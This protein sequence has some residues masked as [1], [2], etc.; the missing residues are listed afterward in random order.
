MDSE[1]DF[2]FLNER[3]AEKFNPLQEWEYIVIQ[4]RS[5]N[6]RLTPLHRGFDYQ[7]A[8]SFCEMENMGSDYHH[9]TVRVVHQGI[10]YHVGDNGLA[11][12]VSKEQ[13]WEIK[14]SYYDARFTEDQDC[15]IEVC[16][17]TYPVFWSW[18]Q[19]PGAGGQM[20]RD[21]RPVTCLAEDYEREVNHCPNCNQPLLSLLEED[22]DPPGEDEDDWW[23]WE[24]VPET[25][26]G[27]KYYNLNS[28]ISCAIHPSGVEENCKDYSQE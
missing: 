13:N 2:V 23:D 5:S 18:R 21:W 17:C 14:Q 10:L 7:K 8:K 3:V 28:E 9:Y 6:L 15:E 27:C 4:T 26:K 24:E 16:S 19:V 22:I 20:V 1:A 12:R 25:C 11:T